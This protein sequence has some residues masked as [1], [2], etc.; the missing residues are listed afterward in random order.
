MEN[1]EKNAGLLIGN[2]NIDPYSSNVFKPDYDNQILENNLEYQR[3]HSTLINK[4]GNRGKFYKCSKDGILFYMPEEEGNNIYINEGLCP[5]CKQRICYFCSKISDTFFNCCIK[6]KLSEMYYGGK[7]MSKGN[8]KDLDFF[9]KAAFIYY[10]IP[11]VNITFFIGIIFNF[12]FYKLTMK[13][14]NEDGYESFLHKNYTRFAIILALNSFTSL[15]LAISFII[16]GILL[17]FIF[18]MLIAFKKSFY[19]FIIGFCLRDWIYL[20]KNFHKVLNMIY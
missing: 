9:E 3:W 17:S 18:L 6:K 20:Y 11:V 15:I 1:D 16:Y 7:E 2:K 10:L 13:K 12:S 8:L 14:N 5:I 19:L 4:Y